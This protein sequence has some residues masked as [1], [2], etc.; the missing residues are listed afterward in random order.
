MKRV[1]LAASAALL[2]GTF[3]TQAFAQAGSFD[4]D[5][6]ASIIDPVQVSEVTALDFGTVV[7]GSAGGVVTIVAA[8]GEVAADDNAVN[9]ARALASDLGAVGEY[10]FDATAG[11]PTF[12]VS[13]DDPTIVL[14]NGT[15]AD[16]MALSLTLGGDV[17]DLAS[18]ATQ[19]VFVGGALTVAANQT[20]GAYTGTFT[21]RAT[22]D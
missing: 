2:V 6:T 4:G 5:V 17:T 22:Y 19:T 16:D 21:I 7:S 20:V 3:S 14:T 10:E 18:G 8:T 11:A 13:L 12:D 15:P 1:L 9:G